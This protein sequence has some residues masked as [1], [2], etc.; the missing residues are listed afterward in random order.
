MIDPAT[1]VAKP[2]K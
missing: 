2:I 1:H